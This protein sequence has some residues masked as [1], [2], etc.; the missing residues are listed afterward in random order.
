M[1]VFACD[2]CGADLGAKQIN[3]KCKSCGATYKATMMSKLSIYG[4]IF[5]GFI[6]GQMI[7]TPMMLQ[8]NISPASIPGIIIGIMASITAVMIFA[9]LALRFLKYEWQGGSK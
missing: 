7:A 1:T 8:N 9:A 4:A 5:L 6:C 3:G 2:N